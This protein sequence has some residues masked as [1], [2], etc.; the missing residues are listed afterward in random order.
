MNPRDDAP[1][2]GGPRVRRLACALAAAALASASAALA[3]DGE[4]SPEQQRAIVMQRF[5]V[6]DTRIDRNPWR[7][8]SAGEFEVLTRAS[9]HDTDWWLDALHRGM[10]LEDRLMPAGWLPAPQVPYTV[11][12]DD[13]D[14]ASNPAG[15]LHVAPLLLHAPGDPLAWDDLAE[16]TRIATMPISSFDDDTLALNTNV[17]GNDTSKLNYASLSLERLARAEPP[18]PGWLLTGILS[19]N[20]GMI[21]EGFDLVLSPDPDE[22]RTIVRAAGPGTLWVSEEETA[23]LLKLLGAN[24]HDPGVAAAPLAFLFESEP[25]GADAALWE[26]EAS[27]FVRWGLLGPGREDPALSRAFL[28]LVR[29]ARSEPVNEKVFTACFGFG[30]GAMKARLDPFL[31]AVLGKPT[32]VPWGMPP[33]ALPPARLREATSDQIG[34]ILGDWLRMKGASLAGTDPGLGRELLSSAGRILERAYREDNGL[35]PDVDLPHA[36]ARDAGAPGNAGLGSATVMG[37]FVV[38][39]K[40]F[41]DPRL[42]AVYGLYERDTGDGAKARELLLAAANAGVPRPA[43]YAALAELRY[44]DALAKPLGADGKLSAGQAAGVLGPLGTALGHGPTADLLHLR[45]AVWTKCE[46][47]PSTADA[48]EIV[49]GCALFPRDTDLA[50]DAAVLCSQSG[51]PAQA[52]ALIDSG[53]VFTTR[54]VNREYFEELRASLGP[55]R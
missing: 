38:S 25:R 51:H 3:D 43:V 18:L 19:R 10:W 54:D 44:A 41:H 14:M 8:A 34:R 23:R 6:S 22:R 27:L 39:A 28:E 15:Q 49:R 21:R 13:T 4:A 53:L 30:Y 33:G 47:Q 35:P 31:R 20:F 11:I 9:E 12:I 26:S 16:V 50:Y 1:T 52:S 40:R 36:Q 46:A 48:D 7:Y 32:S 29:R 55:S 2:A 24:G 5:V 37:P 42:L 17:S 45:V